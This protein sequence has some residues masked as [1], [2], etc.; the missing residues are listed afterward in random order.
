MTNFTIHLTFGRHPHHEVVNLLISVF[1]LSK[2]NLADTPV[3]I[4]DAAD[5]P[6]IT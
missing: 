4:P 2:L 1:L 5:S 6:V 3:N